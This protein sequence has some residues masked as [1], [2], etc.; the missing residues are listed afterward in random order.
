VSSPWTQSDALLFEYET[1]GEPRTSYLI[2]S[3]PRSGSNL[4]CELL[5]ATGV[6]GVPT[7]L[8]HPDFM[9][10]LKERWELGPDDD[11]VR[12]LLAR[13][14]GPN[15]VFGA[16]ANWGQYEEFFGDTDPRGLFPDLRLVYTRRDDHLRQAISWVR[17]LQ[18]MRW[19]STSARPRQERAVRFDRAH[20]ARLLGRIEREE[21]AWNEL[22]GRLGAEPLTVVYEDLVADH[23]TAVR[24]TL[25]F[26][27]VAP[28][29]TLALAPTLEPLADALSDEW[30]ER[31]RAEA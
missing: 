20:I 18:S 17:A 28:P 22:F 26:I 30:A 11:Y 4:L 25:D 9:R 3:V 5:F 31:Y 21:Q 24:R 6:A 7:E 19:V 27:G 14:T 16:K 2:C 23:E 1:P 10:V 15:G 12:F 29:A 13:K 8:F